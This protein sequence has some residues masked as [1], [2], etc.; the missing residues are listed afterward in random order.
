MIFV[1][2]IPT[3]CAV[4][5]WHLLRP[6]KLKT[7]LAKEAGIV[8]W[9]GH[10][11]TWHVG[12]D[13]TAIMAA[14]YVSRRPIAC[15]RTPLDQ[16]LRIIIISAMY[17]CYVENVAR[18]L[19]PKQVVDEVCALSLLYT[20]HVH[21]LKRSVHCDYYNPT[22]VHWLKRSVHCDYYNTTHVTLVKEVC[23]LWLL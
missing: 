2:A 9:D 21:W 18:L 20:T 17:I 11:R 15:K 12:I 5:V 6:Y 1:V 10:G 16:L 19:C 14:L 13:V 22:H 8:V 23:A 4:D 7:S 3:H